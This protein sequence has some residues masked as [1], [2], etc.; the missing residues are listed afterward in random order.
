VATTLGWPHAELWL[1]DEAHCVLRPAAYWTDPGRPAVQ[2]PPE[3]AEG[4]GVAGTAWKIGEP[5]WIPDIAAVPDAIRVQTDDP[6]RL[7]GL[8]AALAIPVLSANR[9]LG[10]LTVFADIAEEPQDSLIALL[11]GIAAH[12]GQFLERRRAEELLLQ[13]AQTKDEY[14]ALVGH[15]LRTPLTS[16]AAYTQLLVDADDATL[17]AE[18]RDLLDVVRR[19]NDQLRRIIDD[20][21]DLAALDAGHATIDPRRIDLGELVAD[22]LDA[23]GLAASEK[24]LTFETSVAREAYV[25]GDRMRLRQVVDNVLSNAVKYTQDRGRVEVVLQSYPDSAVLTVSDNGIG[26]PEAERERIFQRFFRSSLARS[27]GIPGTGLGLAITRT[28][29]HRHGGTITI[30]HHDEPDTGTT[31]TIRIPT[32][33]AREA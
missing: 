20:L 13:L 5:I 16:I 30:A 6:S 1:V 2:P 23:I 33:A 19:N 7:S 22:A 21:L 14:I 18:G 27:R 10:V 32:A 29:L 31:V 12:V 9:T 4:H 17:R 26:V 24:H 25:D 11:S 28:I 8:H 3:L 15:E